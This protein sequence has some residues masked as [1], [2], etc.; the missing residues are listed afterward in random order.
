MGQILE[1]TMEENVPQIEDEDGNNGLILGEK[2]LPQELITEILCWVDHKSLLSSQLV[3]KRWK[4]LM[5][6]YV[7]R[8]KA[9]LTLGRSLKMLKNVPWQLFY[10]ICKKQPFDR[11]LLKNHSGENGVDKHWK[12]LCQ[13]GD[14]WKVECPPLGV[15]ALPSEIAGSGEKQHCFVTSYY[16]CRKQ[17]VVKLADEGLTPQLLDVLQ[18][19]IV[20]S[21]WYSSRWDCPATYECIVKLIGKKK[22]VLDS[23]EF[24]RSIE[25]NLQDTWHQMKHEFRNYGPG[26]EQIIF[27]H[28]GSDNLFW[29]GHY[30]SKMT[31]ASIVIKLP[32][33]HNSDSIK[34]DCK[35][36]V[37]ENESNTYHHHRN[38]QNQNSFSR[39]PSLEIDEI[40]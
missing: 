32:E 38:S 31:R 7:W 11:N 14:H 37:P 3:C 17:Q 29:A 39:R 2:Y 23:F 4:A 25:N 15:P 36:G 20:V 34:V 8:K 30:G 40:D 5:E 19:P 10:V 26:L 18:P 21:E 6:T 35:T 1:G 24:Q 16:T 27:Q 9:E 33:A 12:I 22:K 28:A 13:G